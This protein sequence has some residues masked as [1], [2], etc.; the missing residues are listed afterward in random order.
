MSLYG[1][2][3]IMRQLAVFMILL[4]F[5]LGAL[6]QEKA[7]PPAFGPKDTLTVPAVYYD[8]EW[9]P[10]AQLEVV[11]IS[12]LPPDK[13][14]K[15]LQEHNRLRR[16]VYATY[17]Y[18]ISASA[19]INDVN[20]KLQGVTS[21]KER[22]KYIKS[23]ES[24]LRKQF[25]EPLSNLSVYQGKVLMKLIYRQTGSDCYDIIKEYRGGL[26]ARVYQTAYFFFGGDFKQSY[27]AVHDP[28]DRQIE[29][30]VQELTNHWYG[31]NRSA[32][33]GR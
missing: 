23:R 30:I 13:L 16:A 32:A 28:V 27:D 9:M 3:V 11:Y 15:Y 17:S 19:I 22:K 4:S 2:Q 29:S 33:A 24:E 25:G 14:A 18:A 5:S 6:A 21:K 8:G 31:G 26:N 10:Y 12:N 1:D 7:P 20:A